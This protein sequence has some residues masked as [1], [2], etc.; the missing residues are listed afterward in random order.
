MFSGFTKRV[1][2]SAAVL[3]SSIG[4]VAMAHP[5]SIELNAVVNPVACNKLGK[6]CI[7]MGGTVGPLGT[8]PEGNIKIDLEEERTSGEGRLYAGSIEVKDEDDFL[9]RA[10]L[11]VLLRTD[12]DG[13]PTS[14]RLVAELFNKNVPD[15]STY[16]QLELNSLPELLDN[17]N[18]LSVSGP[19]SID[20]ERS[21]YPILH[22]SRKRL[23]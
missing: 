7:E 5:T 16:T 18:D 4:G 6:E 2:F 12:S 23:E 15:Q 3:G 11:T 17:L 21:Y 10:K 1:L 13:E 19:R 9:G 20:K 14:Y 22:L 8:P